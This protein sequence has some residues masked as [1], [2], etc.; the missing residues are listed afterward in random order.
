M[1]GLCSLIFVVAVEEARI[2]HVRQRAR[3]LVDF[4]SPLNI[5]SVT[6]TDLPRLSLVVGEYRFQPPGTLSPGRDAPTR[7][8]TASTLLKWGGP[9]PAWLDGEALLTGSDER[10]RTLDRTLAAFA[11]GPS[12]AR[13]VTGCAGATS[14]YTARANETE[15]WSTHA[16]AAGYLARG[17]VRLDACALPEL[18]AAE[19]VG[20][21]QTQLA[22]VTAVPRAT[23]VEFGPERHKTRAY[24]PERERYAKLA[25]AEA[26]DA[27]ERTLVESLDARLPSGQRVE[28][29]LTAGADSRVAAVALKKAERS[30][31]AITVAPESGSDDARGAAVVARQIGI[32]HRIRG[33]ELQPDE[34]ALDL[35][36]AEV[37]WSEG[38][39]PLNGFA[40]GEAETSDLV[41]TGGGGEI[42]RAWYYRWKARNYRHPRRRQLARVLSHLHWRIGGA[43]ARAHE[44]LDAA[45]LRWLDAAF[46]TGHDGWAA[47]DVIYDEE[48]L[49]RWGRAR[50][51][52]S[53]APLLYAFSTPTLTQAFLSLPLEDRISD[54]FH[55]QFLARHAP[56]LLVPP[57]PAQ[58]R[59]LPRSVRRLSA[60]MR[61]RRGLE[62]VPADPSIADMLRSRPRTRAHI[63]DDVLERDVLAS[64]MGRAWLRRTRSAFL[65]GQQ[66]AV[67]T[68]FL[69]TSIIALDTAISS[70]NA[71]SR[72]GSSSLPSD[73]TPDG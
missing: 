69:A 31:E 60:A 51:H 32:P 57:P 30:F 6:I 63:A 12:T 54:G 19:F 47:L 10:L 23:V 50:L 5:L 46:C 25:A 18:F 72:T 15:A 66:H 44:L 24:W 67:D 70:L 41:V 61:H 14:L 22:D 21:T 4:Y 33:Y 16:V 73:P 43:S 48:R 59:A 42:A 35:I 65:D 28:L 8:T 11:A 3:H 45:I 2:G 20:G 26:F 53:R 9:F 37:R 34:K 52:R 29:G 39:A 36:N 40:I 64:V 17:H 13:L 7:G 49:G 68:A 38:I 71:A 58:R 27:A 62:D 55:R 56:S 1:T